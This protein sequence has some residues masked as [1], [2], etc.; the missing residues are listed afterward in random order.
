MRTALYGGLEEMLNH[1][2]G[3]AEMASWC[4]LPKELFKEGAALHPEK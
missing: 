1:V 4:V 2:W 3:T